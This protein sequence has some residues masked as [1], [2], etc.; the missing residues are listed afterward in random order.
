MM[1]YL[2]AEEVNCYF[3]D[4][5]F[6]LVIKNTFSTKAERMNSLMEARKSGYFYYKED[7]EKGV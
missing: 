5:E 7:S 6:P 1:A 3:P 2:L 4:F